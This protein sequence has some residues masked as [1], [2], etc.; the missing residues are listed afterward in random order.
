MNNKTRKRKRYSS[1]ELGEISGMLKSDKTAADIARQEQ[2]PAATVRRMRLRYEKFGTLERRLVTGR[3]RITSTRT[4][5]L[6]ARSVRKD[7]FISARQ[8][9]QDL[10]LTNISEQTIRNR[11]LELCGYSSYWSV[12]KPYIS[13]ANRI[14]RLN[15]A[16]KYINKP[17][18]YWRKIVWSD[19]SPFNYIMKSRERVWRGPNERYLPE[20]TIA[21]IKQDKKIMVWGCF[22]ASGVGNLYRISNN[23]NAERYVNI[24]NTQL[25]PTSTKL[26]LDENFIFQQDNDPKHTANVA[27]Q[28]INR[29]HI[30][31]LDWPPQSPDLNPIENLEYFGL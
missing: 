3:P 29:H 25:L 1:Y 19:E 11:I 4:D 17:V 21:T 2:I 24:L 18:S 22:A 26:F 23:L 6:I 10:G 8:I 12:H 13:E 28:W 30:E 15:F 27:K 7:R 16:N 31:T 9:K 14:K 20:C 5:T